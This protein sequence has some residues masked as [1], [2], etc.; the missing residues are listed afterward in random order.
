ML[1]TLLKP[2]GQIF[3]TIMVDTPLHQSFYKLAAE[4]TWA[5]YLPN[6]KIFC[7]YGK[8]PSK[9]LTNLA[10]SAGFKVDVCE[11]RK[12]NAS[13]EYY[14][15]NEADIIRIFKLCKTCY[16]F[17]YGESLDLSLRQHPINTRRITRRLLQ[18]SFEELPGILYL[19]R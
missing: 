15:G 12:E 13:V 17:R 6:E 19:F 16:V 11:T 1:R 14:S 10:T 5:K 4:Q 8:S 9:F 3:I 18:R 2:K 7:D